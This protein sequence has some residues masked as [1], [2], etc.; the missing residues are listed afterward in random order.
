MQCATL[1]LETVGA[2]LCTRLQ[3]IG[4][5]CMIYQKAA[6]KCL[7]MHLIFHGEEFDIEKIRS[8]VVLLNTT[9]LI[10]KIKI[11]DGYSEKE[12]V[13]IIKMSSVKM[14]LW[15]RMNVRKL[16]A[17]TAVTNMV[18]ILYIMLLQ[19]RLRLKTQR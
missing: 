2:V 3:D 10:D 18:T 8:L 16:T 13:E 12:I 1:F 5:M 17:S 15:S 4:D 7:V 11:V 19:S 14:L 9:Q 6:W